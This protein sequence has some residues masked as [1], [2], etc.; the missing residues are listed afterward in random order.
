M[1]NDW[2]LIDDINELDSPAL[3]IFPERVKKNIQTAVSMVENVDRL[4]PHVKTNK[5]PDAVRL[6]LDAG[7][8]KFKCAT[9]AEAE[10]L[11]IIGAPDV[12]LAYQSL[13][14]K[15]KRF[16]E[17]IKKFP[18]TKFSCL[19]DNVAAVKE[20]DEVFSAN[21]MQG[22]V[23][24]DLNVG[25][26][27][28]GIV[29]GDGAIEL[30]KICSTAKGLSFAGFHV[31]DGH[32]RNPDISIRTKESDEAFAAV[33]KMRDELSA[34][35]I[36]VKNII[37]GGSPAFPIHAKRK[38]VECSPGTFIYWDKTYL[39]Q[40]PEQDFLPA[41]ILVTRIISLPSSTRI[42]TDLGHKSVAAENEISKRIFFLNASGPIPVGHSEEHL[43]LEGNKDHGFKTGDV[44]YGIPYH[45]CPTV[46]LYERTYTVENGKLTGEWKNISRNRKIT[47]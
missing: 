11:G 16:I 14:P 26:N 42:C 40:C 39:D 23:Y 13:G 7:I 15:L 9:I 41:A 6:M 34:I 17:L 38:N 5:S 19:V 20:Q 2:Y 37:A 46:A 4:R 28:T 45:I 25:M 47:I 18:A 36:E 27:R 30:C 43:V 8:T 33:E 29:P 24:V 3:I 10:M 44:L 31:Y 21:K 22:M 12:S 1:N 35:G 32:L